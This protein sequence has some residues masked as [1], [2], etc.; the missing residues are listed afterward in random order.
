MN[1]DKQYRIALVLYTQ[2]L[3]YD[4]R[5]RKEIL[6]IQ[7]LFSNVSFH[8][9]AVEANNRE[10]EGGTSYGIPYRIPYLKSRDQF[11]SG[12]HTLIKAWDFYQSIKKD[13]K[14]FDVIWCADVETFLF[15]LL[16]R[17]KPIV[18]DLHELPN[19]F[20]VNGMM[21]KLFNCLESRCSV[22]IHANEQRLQYLIDKGYIR[23]QERNF[24]LR[25]YPQFNEIDTDYDETYQHFD[26][27]LGDSK[28]AYLQG[29]N[30]QDRA[31]IE[32]LEAI[33]SVEGLKGV[34]VG[35]TRPELLSLLEEKHSQEELRTRLY[36]TGRVKQ[37]KTPQYIK[38]CIFG[39]VFYKNTCMNNWYC[40]ANRFFQN[41]INGNPVIVGQNPSLKETV[42]DYHLGVVAETDG[43]NSKAIHEAIMELLSR[44]D[45]YKENVNEN[46]D[47]WL[48]NQQEP[49]VREI[50][51]K[52]LS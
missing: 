24:V 11:A 1:S 47:N 13:L 16:T 7:N 49:I 26:D 46:K 25:N 50:V 4:D 22:M 32:S 14:R 44:Y 2:G 30:G 9:F 39:M 33:L 18:W 3:D 45:Y 10:E 36:F 41:I 38:R 23:H 12:T 8:I 17:K 42:N 48:W 15:V 34:V 37:L 52:M 20:L 35:Y 43:S 40:E 5:I 21:K 27:W 28:C 51:N 19:R 29:I 6:T 31:D